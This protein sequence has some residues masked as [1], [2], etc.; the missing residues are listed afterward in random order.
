MDLDKTWQMYKGGKEW[1]YKIYDE[2]APGALG[3]GAKN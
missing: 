3:K 2:I 1:P